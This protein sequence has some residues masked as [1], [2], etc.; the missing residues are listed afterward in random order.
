VC[1]VRGITLIYNASK[2]VN[3]GFIRHMILG[4]ESPVINVH[5]ENK[6]NL[7]RKGTEQ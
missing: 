5:T 2:I 1:K 4:D 7:K 3:F 6:I